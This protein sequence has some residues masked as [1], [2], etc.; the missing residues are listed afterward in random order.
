MEY[1]TYIY[2]DER[3]LPYYVGKGCGKRAFRQS[4]RSVLVPP[5]ARILI[6]HWASEQEAFVMEMWYIGFYGSKD[7][8]T[9]MLLN[10]DD[11][12]RAPSRATCSK[13]G[14]GAV[15]SGLLARICILGGRA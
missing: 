15:A 4:G 6:Q 11:G 7:L 9:G 5:I 12:G 8:G 10:Q 14:R 2:Y 1:Y 13:R 3:M